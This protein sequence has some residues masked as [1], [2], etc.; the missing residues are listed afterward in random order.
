MGV[1][2]GEGRGTQFKPDTH[3][4]ILPILYLGWCNFGGRNAP[5]EGKTH[6]SVRFL[7]LFRIIELVSKTWW[8]TLARKKKKKGKWGIWMSIKFFLFLCHNC[9]SGDWSLWEA[10]L[11][12]V[13]ILHIHRHGFSSLMDKDIQVFS[14]PPPPY[15]M[16][17]CLPCSNVKEWW[18]SLSTA[19]LL[20]VLESMS[21]IH[22][23]H[24]LGF[25][26]WAAMGEA[27]QNPSPQ[28]GASATK[29]FRWFYWYYSEEQEL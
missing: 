21:I 18:S 7:K 26:T 17:I 9:L 19:E 10:Q 15:L 25:I 3:V 2:W 5:L 14:A 11:V 16:G 1:G 22:K 20:L 24:N 23:S 4:F 6:W 13:H 28:A 27:L 29:Q 8:N 12:T